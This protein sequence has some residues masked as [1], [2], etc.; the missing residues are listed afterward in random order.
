MPLAKFIKPSIAKVLTA[1]VL[2]AAFY[3]FVGGLF[4]LPLLDP[5]ATWCE[6]ELNRTDMTASQGPP[7]R[8][9]PQG[10]AEGY[11]GY[12]FRQECLNDYLPWWLLALVLSYLLVCLLPSVP[13]KAR[14]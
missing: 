1:V 8:P 12:Y 6:P 10:A 11:T 14:R 13:L 5:S 9:G 3:Y 2:G 7:V 4:G